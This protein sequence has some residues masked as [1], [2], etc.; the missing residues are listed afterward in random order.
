MN[1][2]QHWQERFESLGLGEFWRELMRPGSPTAFLAAQS[3]RIAQPA[4][5]VF[6]DEAGVAAIDSLAARLEGPDETE[7]QS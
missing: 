3:L 4:L 2:F 7:T 6:T 5:S 1:V